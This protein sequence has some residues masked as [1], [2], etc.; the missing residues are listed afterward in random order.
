MRFAPGA[1][2]SRKAEPVLLSATAQ[3]AAMLGQNPYANAS[4]FDLEAET[5]VGGSM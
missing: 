4:N 1:I 5:N 3:G 2:P